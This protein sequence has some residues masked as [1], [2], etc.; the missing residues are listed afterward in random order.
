MGQNGPNV[1]QPIHF[2]KYLFGYNM[3]FRIKYLS[4]CWHLDDIILI[5]EIE[6]FYLLSSKTE[7]AMNTICFVYKIFLF[8]AHIHP[9]DIGECITASCKYI[10]YSIN[11]NTRLLTKDNDVMQIIVFAE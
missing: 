7:N 8:S 2:C 5:I 6:N 1:H 4:M 9:K 10:T 11:Q 3:R